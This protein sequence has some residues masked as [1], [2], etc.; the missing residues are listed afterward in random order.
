[1]LWSSFGEQGY[2]MG[3]ARSNSGSV[4]GP[5][6][7]DPEPLWATDGGHGMF[8]RDFAGQLFVTLHQPNKS[9]LERAAFFPLAESDDSLRLKR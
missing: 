2:A 6:T 1:M 4:L 7:H 9:P 8:F 5:W 3:L